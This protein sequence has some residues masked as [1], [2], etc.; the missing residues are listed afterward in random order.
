MKL[1]FNNHMKVIEPI[2]EI[3]FIKMYSLDF[4]KIVPDNRHLKLGESQCNAFL[5]KT[6]V[7]LKIG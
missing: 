7:L 1:Q 5:R 2:F 4:S 6:S 3:F